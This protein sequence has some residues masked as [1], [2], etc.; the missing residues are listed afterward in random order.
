MN[1]HY[2]VT[3]DRGHLKIYEETKA[4]GQ[5]T[6]TLVLTEAMDFPSGAE[7]YSARDTDMAGRFPGARGRSGGM[8]IDE[9]LPME[10]EE[11][12][13]RV[14]RLATEINAFLRNRPDAS[15]DFAAPAE[16]HSTVLEQLSPKTRLR[17][18]RTL[19]KDL[20]NQPAA[21]V[22]AHFAGAG[23]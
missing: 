9:R 13:R 14:D 3:V 10:R 7:S 17:L 8:S 20:T 15:W 6:P 19:P 18:R 12:R 16:L 1:E 4:R 21:E 23:V 2:I 11:D 22:R 5:F